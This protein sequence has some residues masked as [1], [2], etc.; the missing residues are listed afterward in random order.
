MRRSPFRIRGFLNELLY[1]AEEPLPA[2]GFESITVDYPEVDVG[3]LGYQ[4]HWMIVFFVLSIV[5]A[6]ILRGPMGVT[7]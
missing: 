2:G 5:F 6:F 3:V 4:T 1:P 7:F